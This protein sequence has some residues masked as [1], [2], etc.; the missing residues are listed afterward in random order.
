MTAVLDQ[1]IVGRVIGKAPSKIVSMLKTE[2]N[3]TQAKKENTCN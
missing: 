2:D 3:V 1:F